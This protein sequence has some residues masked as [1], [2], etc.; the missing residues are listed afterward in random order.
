[1]GTTIKLVKWYDRRNCVM[2]HGSMCQN[3]DNQWAVHCSWVLRPEHRS[4]QKPESLQPKV[5]TGSV[6]KVS[7]R[8]VQAEIPG[9]LFCSDTG[10][11]LFCSDTINDP[12]SPTAVDP[13]ETNL[14]DLRARRS[15]ERGRRLS[16]YAK[17]A[18]KQR[19]PL[20]MRATRNV[21]ASKLLCH[22]TKT[23]P[24]RGL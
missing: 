12:S 1:M 5:S 6:H 10:A 8:A 11:C 15:R 18:F 9:C 4:I 14:F 16:S 23:D 7:H 22:S 2:C 21:A 3:G 24:L 20:N 19:A 13:P 17:R